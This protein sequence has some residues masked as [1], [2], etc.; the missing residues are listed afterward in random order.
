MLRFS[1]SLLLQDCHAQD[2]VLLCVETQL[3]K[4]MDSRQPLKAER[5]VQ[6]MLTNSG[7]QGL[8]EDEIL[9]QE[10]ENDMKWNYFYVSFV[11]TVAVALRS[12]RSAFRGL[13]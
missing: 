12:L 7:L 13:N 4:L 6:D 10:W 8:I 11:E 9:A 2:S 1:H 5:S 3:R